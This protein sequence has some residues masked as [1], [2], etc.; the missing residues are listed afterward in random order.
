MSVSRCA[1]PSC[2]WVFRVPDSMLG[3]RSKCMN[4]VIPAKQ[5]LNMPNGVNQKSARTTSRV[6]DKFAV[7]WI[8]DFH[9]H[10]HDRA[11]REVLSLLALLFR[12]D[13]VFKC[14]RTGFERPLTP[15]SVRLPE[16]VEKTFTHRRRRRAS[17][18]RAEKPSSRT[19]ASRVVGQAASARADFG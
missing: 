5:F 4:P 7:S 3:K 9:C 18:R 11:G 1:C 10:L 15:E 17:R 8:Q 12:V 14:G 16:C 13:E 19:P 6:N 2:R